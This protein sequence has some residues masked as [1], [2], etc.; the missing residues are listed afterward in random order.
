MFLGIAG[1]LKLAHVEYIH[2]CVPLVIPDHQ[3]QQGKRIM[4]KRQKLDACP[5][6]D[7]ENCG[8][9]D[10]DGDVD[11]DVD[12]E[13]V[14]IQWS[15]KK[16]KD[17]AFMYS[18]SQKIVSRNPM[19]SLEKVAFLSKKKSK[20]EQAQQGSTDHLFV[21]RYLSHEAVMNRLMFLVL[22]GLIIIFVI[23]SCNGGFLNSMEWMYQNLLFLEDY[24][25]NVPYTQARFLTPAWKSD[26]IHRLPQAC[27][28]F[29]LKESILGNITNNLSNASLD[30][31][32][33]YNEIMQD[34]IMILLLVGI[35][36]QHTTIGTIPHL[37]NNLL[38]PAFTSMHWNK[39]GALFLE[40]E[41]QSTSIERNW[42]GERNMETNAENEGW[43]LNLTFVLEHG[44]LA[45]LL[46]FLLR[47]T[48]LHVL[49]LDADAYWM[50]VLTRRHLESNMVSSLMKGVDATF[51]AQKFTLQGSV[52][53]MLLPDARFLNVSLGN[54]EES[55]AMHLPSVFNLCLRQQAIVDPRIMMLWN[56]VKTKTWM[57]VAASFSNRWR[58]HPFGQH[59][60]VDIGSVS[61]I[62]AALQTAFEDRCQRMNNN[63]AR[64]DVGNYESDDRGSD[65]GSDKGYDR[66]YDESYDESYDK[67][68]DKSYDEDTFYYTVFE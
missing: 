18:S 49:Y 1:S 16:R 10:V 41:N 7:M 55:V 20:A 26:V 62:N 51:A 32:M 2:E 61:S 63:N 27:N 46:S 13:N 21:H 36:K 44:T 43:N 4:L 6:D 42:K 57:G 58:K 53:T 5:E 22:V 40:M 28:H 52:H 38:D 19:I 50:P 65:K 31:L 54:G 33:R 37:F 23:T 59:V 8:E 48:G 67:S 14:E 12:D 29:Y 30:D 68:Y 47:D 64:D 15:G 25:T 9:D 34:G 35:K 45:P 66:G 60:A 24:G 39:T 11:G 3:N 17:S 56:T